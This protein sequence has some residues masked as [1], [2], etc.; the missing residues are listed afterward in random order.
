MFNQTCN[1]VDQSAGFFSSCVRPQD[2]SSTSVGALPGRYDAE[3]Y[4]ARRLS[5]RDDYAEDPL[6]TCSHVAGP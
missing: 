6:E 1:F 4:S 2:G 3:I 5:T